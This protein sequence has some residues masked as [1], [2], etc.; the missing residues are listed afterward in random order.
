MMAKH[1]FNMTLCE[2]HC[3]CLVSNACMKSISKNA[4]CPGADGFFIRAPLWCSQ[5]TSNLHASRVEV[6]S[7]PFVSRKQVGCPCHVSAEVTVCIILEDCSTALDSYRTPG[8]PGCRRQ[9]LRCDCPGR[10]LSQLGRAA[11]VRWL[12]R[13]ARVHQYIAACC[14]D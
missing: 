6:L 8:N 12:K 13:Q 1:T 2:R 9:R 3:M 4:Q 11:D 5:R 14:P 10:L 7:W